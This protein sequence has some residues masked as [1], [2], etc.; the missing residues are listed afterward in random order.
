[1]IVVTYID[2]QVFI[3]KFGFVATRFWLM[4]YCYLNFHIDYIF[5]V[6][7]DLISSFLLFLSFSI[8]VLINWQDFGN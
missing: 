2:F 4:C 3:Y 5:V 8:S 6:V 7:T 1:M